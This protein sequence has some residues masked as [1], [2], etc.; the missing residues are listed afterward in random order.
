MMKMG[1]RKMMVTTIKMKRMVTQW[2][3]RIRRGMWGEMMGR[4]GQPRQRF[5]SLAQRPRQS[6]EV[7]Q[8]VLAQPSLRPKQRLRL[9]LRQQPNRK[10]KQRANQR[11]RDRCHSRKGICWNEKAMHTRRPGQQLR[12]KGKM[13]N[14]QR[15]QAVRPA[16][17]CIHVMHACMCFGVPSHVNV[18]RCGGICKVHLA[19]EGGLWYCHTDP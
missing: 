1:L 12:R 13:R 6:R 10:P 9:R 11:P 16:L 4:L 2:M 17:S 19:L 14:L 8:R 3:M 15:L 5:Q 7:G 18:Q